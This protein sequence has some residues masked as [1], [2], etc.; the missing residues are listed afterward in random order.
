[1]L[2]LLIILFAIWN[3]FVI[4]WK[5]KNDQTASKKWHS[6]GFWAR[7]G[8]LIA[9]LLFYLPEYAW[10]I[11]CPGFILGGWYGAALTTVTTFIFSYWIYNLI[12]NKINGW[13]WDYLGEGEYGDMWYVGGFILSGFLLLVL[14]VIAIEMTY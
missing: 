6:V 2:Y 9:V 14:L 10:V 11:V 13:K 1:M 5:L 8:L 3:G 7:A 4:K 12:I